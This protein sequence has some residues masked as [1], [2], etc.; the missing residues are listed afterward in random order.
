MR[1][2]RVAQIGVLHEHSDGKMLTLRNRMQDV[3]EVVAIAAENQ[4]AAQSWRPHAWEQP[5]Y[6]GLNRVGKEELFRMELDAVFVETELR[7]LV[8]TAR[9]CLAHDLPVHIDKPG[10]LTLEPYAEL[11]RDY[12]RAGILFQ[13][14]YMLRNS[15][16]VQQMKQIVRDGVLGEIYEVDANMHRPAGSELF[17]RY[18][19]EIPGGTMFDYGSHLIDVI[20]DMLGV[21]EKITAFGTHL[22]PYGIRDNSVAVFRYGKALA[23]VHCAMSSAVSIPNRRFTVRGSN[24]ILEIFPL[25]QG[26]DRTAGHPLVNDIP[27]KHP[28]RTPFAQAPK[29]DRV[30]VRIRDDADFLLHTINPFEGYNAPDACRTARCTAISYSALYGR[31]FPARRSAANSRSWSS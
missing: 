23:T 9:E 22:S 3:F 30:H 1:K 24:G 28:G 27:V 6:A 10:G 20:L 15:K 29:P 2:L 12:H 25:E 17:C 13:P 7:E 21:P 14:G 5:C 16:A 31:C 8:P 4:D 26:Y 18:M 11:V 19:R